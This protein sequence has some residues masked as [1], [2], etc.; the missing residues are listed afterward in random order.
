MKRIT[1]FLLLVVAILPFSV[2][3]QTQPEDPLVKTRPR[4]VTPQQSQT[5]PAR[6]D[7]K[8]VPPADAASTNVSPLKPAIPDEAEQRGKDQSALRV[9]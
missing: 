9:V 8:I 1:P 7:N 6:N 4:T 3:A 2:S 5:A